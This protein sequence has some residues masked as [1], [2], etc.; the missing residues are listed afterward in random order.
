MFMV[1]LALGDHEDV[2]RAKGYGA[3]WETG[4]GRP[5]P[6]ALVIHASVA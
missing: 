1:A 3:E 5:L 4:L 6:V 2:V